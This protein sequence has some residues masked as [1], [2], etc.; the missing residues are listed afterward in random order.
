METKRYISKSEMKRDAVQKSG[1]CIND[2]AEDI[3]KNAVEH[4]WW[5]KDRPI[6]ET[7][8]LIT[9]EVA[10]AMEAYRN[11]DYEN[12]AEEL[13]DIVIRVLDAMVGYG[14]NPETEILIKHGINKKRP[15]RHGG[16]VC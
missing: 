1:M 13:A 4:G 8:M 15:Y 2:I 7:L 6:P 14:I 11:D 12:F 10:E 5:E 16:K 9:T 3:H